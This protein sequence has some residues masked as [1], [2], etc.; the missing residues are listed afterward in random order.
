MK[1]Q[2]M[3]AIVTIVDRGKANKV[4]ETYTK[5][6]VASHT[7]CMGR[8]TASSEILDILGL[9]SSEKD[10]VM[11]VAFSA[12][13]ESLM[14]E[15]NNNLRSSFHSKG[16]VFMLT[17]TGITNLMAEALKIE[18]KN[19]RGGI[20]FMEQEQNNSLILITVSQGYTDEVMNTAKKAGATGGTV[21]RAR[22]TGPDNIDQFYGGVAEPEKEVIAILASNQFR[23]AIME[24]VNQK[25]GLNT[26][27]HAVVC[28][29][30]VD[31][32]IKLG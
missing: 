1:K 16:I 12:A 31:K 10:V 8:G 3:K 18:T 32:V 2:G 23:N 28:S 6:G 17:L 15:L 26:P 9:D 30:A 19:H 5:Q 7:I 14:N 20:N 11:S 13:A 24:E 27:A 4:T 25:H 29:L 22:W 21:I